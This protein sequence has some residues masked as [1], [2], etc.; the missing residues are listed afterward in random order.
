MYFLLGQILFMASD[1]NPPGWLKQKRRILSH[2][3][4]LSHGIQDRDIAGP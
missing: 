4:G 1:L 3:Y 2:P